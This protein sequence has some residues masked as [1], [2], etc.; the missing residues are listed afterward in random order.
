MF[1]GAY[2]KVISLFMKGQEEKRRKRLKMY[3]IYDIWLKSTN[4]KENAKVIK[5]KFKKDNTKE[6]DIK[7]EEEIA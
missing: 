3:E 1:I 6:E 2:M 4:N 5:V 7:K